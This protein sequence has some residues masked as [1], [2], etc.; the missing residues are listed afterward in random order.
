MIFVGAVWILALP[1]EQLALEPKM[2]EHALQPGQ[3]RRPLSSF[4]PSSPLTAFFV[5]R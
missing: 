1:V 3:V 5:A 2:D 4:S